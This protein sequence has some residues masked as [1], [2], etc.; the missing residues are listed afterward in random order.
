MIEYTVYRIEDDG[1]TTEVSSHVS[2]QESL[3]EGGRIIEHVDHDFAYYLESDFGRIATLAEGRIGYR[4]W[5]MKTGRLNP[6][7]ED[8]FDHDVDELLIAERG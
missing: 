6:S 5:A 7:L 4:M 8:R 2:L 1:T 3:C